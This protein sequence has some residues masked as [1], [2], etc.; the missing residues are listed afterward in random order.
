[1]HSYD[2][3]VLVA[4]IGGTNASFCVCGINKSK[5]KNIELFFRKNY[6]TK[7]IENIYTPVNEVLSLIYDEKKIEISKACFSLAGP[8]SLDRK[9][10]KMTNSKLNISLSDLY[11]HTLLKEVILLNDIEAIGYGI[12][13]LE[14]GHQIISIIPPKKLYSDDK[15]ISSCIVAP[16]TGLG[17]GIITNKSYPE[18]D[19]FSLILPSEAGHTD[20]VAITDMEKKLVDYLKKNI[21]K[22][23]HPDYERVV[24]GRGIVNI[25]NFLRTQNIEKEN[26]L[27]IM[28]DKIEDSQK[29]NAIN[30][31]HNHNKT[32][33]LVLEFFLNG[34]AR[35][36][37]DLALTN[38][39][40][41]GIY[42]AGGIPPKIYNLLS[43]LSFTETFYECDRNSEILKK[44]PIYLILDKDVNIYGCCHKLIQ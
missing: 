31:Y 35:K 2:E 39:S 27:L 36:I 20:Y 18:D 9:S 22:Y 30:K 28:I 16:G 13:Y 38:L 1:M 5:K 25:Y 29:P 44:I 21:T 19:R 10:C 41:G 3:Y 24:S 43:N 12:P 4:D 32:C 23:R 33:N 8:I 40:Y 37:R 26:D 34:L 15:E 7:D 17:C 14:M 11:K 6:L 42:L